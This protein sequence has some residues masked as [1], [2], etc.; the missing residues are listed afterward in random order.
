MKK[1]ISIISVMTLT[2]FM[3]MGQNPEMATDTISIDSANSY[4]YPSMGDTTKIRIGKKELHIVELEGITHVDIINI[5]TNKKDTSITMKDDTIMS[6]NR[7]RMDRDQRHRGRNKKFRGH[8]AGV[9][10]GWNN[11]LNSSQ[12][13]S[14]GN[15]DEFMDLNTGRS[16]AFHL[17]VIDYEFPIISNYLGLVTGLGLE[18]DNY[19][20]DNNNSIM[21]LNGV[22]VEKPAPMSIVYKKSKLATG[23]VT[24][25]LLLETQI[26]GRWRGVFY[27]SAGIFGSVKT[28]SYT[29]EVYSQAGDEKKIKVHNDFNLSPFRYGL[30]A[31]IGFGHINLFANYS[32]TPFFENNRGPELYPITIGLAVN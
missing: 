6:D 7:E 8:Y 1:I 15:G 5:E 27:I 11:F 17:N 13:L 3:M 22:S 21:S 32:L 31:K 4:S 29:K 16:L 30:M 28:W 19:F 2:V 14:R 12:S 26:H 18:L 9:E 10:L 20:F 23:Y 24:V 25:P